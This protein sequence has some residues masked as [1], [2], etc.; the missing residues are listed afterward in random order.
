MDNIKTKKWTLT[1]VDA[2]DGTGDGIVELPDDM[3][4]ASGWHKGDTLEFEVLPE[5]RVLLYRK[6]AADAK[7][8]R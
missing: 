2:D 3:L 6:L 7:S 8:Y 1:I 5:G 4:V